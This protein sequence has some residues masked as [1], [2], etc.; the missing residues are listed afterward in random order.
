MP[1]SS[2]TVRKKVL[3]IIS[4]DLWA[5]A[6]AQAYTLLKHLKTL[7]DVSAVLMNDGEL[8]TRLRAC[9]I[10]VKIFDETNLSTWQIFGL[11]RAHIR[12]LKPNIVHTH[13]Q[14]EN[15]LGALANA[16]TVRARCVRTAHGAAEFSGNWK[17]DLKK[18][19]ERWVTRIFHDVIIS[20]SNELK[21]K[22]AVDYP[23]TMIKVVHNG[24]DVTELKAKADITDFKRQQPD[25][26]H[27]GIVGRLVPVKR[28]DI[29]LET[30]AIINRERNSCYHFH[31]IGDGPLRMDLENMAIQFDLSDIVTFHG[32]CSETPSYINS[33]DAVMMC[34]DHEGLPMVAL[35]T[36]ALGKALI[37]HVSGAVEQLLTEHKLKGVTQQDARNYSEH[38]KA[39]FE[40]PLP[41]KSIY[42][43]NINAENTSLIYKNHWD[44][45]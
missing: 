4:G 29:F 17:T 37:S 33:L 39:G 25:K 31:V 18:N 20:V 42:L 30:A 8:A 32:H 45:Q 41:L 44:Q 24:V 34:S 13:R 38:I 26:K 28:V 36:I 9:D 6:E 7:C 15:I 22:L 40:K 1:N 14:K 10:P 12:H 16:T 21:E 43:A 3:H 23:T 11:L 19:T 35:E 27:I 5:G 2:P